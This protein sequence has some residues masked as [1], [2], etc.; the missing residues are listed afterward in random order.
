MGNTTVVTISLAMTLIREFVYIQSV[1]VTTILLLAQNKVATSNFISNIN[2]SE[3]Y[4][5]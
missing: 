4:D 3:E 2:K 5:D 1:P